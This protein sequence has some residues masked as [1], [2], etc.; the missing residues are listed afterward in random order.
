MTM[1]K[2]KKTFTIY[3]DAQTGFHLI[4]DG[5]L[6]GKADGLA[7]LATLLQQYPQWRT[8]YSDVQIGV[9]ETLVITTDGFEVFIEQ[10]NLKTLAD[11]DASEAQIVARF[12]KARLPEGL[13]AVLENYLNYTS[14]LWLCALPDC[15]KMPICMLTP[16]Y[17][18]HTCCPM[19][20][21]TE[22]SALRT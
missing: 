7:V 1:T 11:S 21:R 13:Q 16:D 2:A 4:G 19:T 22:R 10:N 18:V 12:L 17:T 8:K 6:G 20:R 3:N 15:S 5:V 14:T 9:P